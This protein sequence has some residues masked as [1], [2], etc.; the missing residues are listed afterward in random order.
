MRYDL[1]ITPW[2]HL[3]S[4]PLSGRNTLMYCSTRVP[5]RPESMIYGSQVAPTIR[6]EV[7]IRINRLLADPKIIRTCTAGSKGRW[8]EAFTAGRTR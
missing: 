8:P 7:L 4:N 1:D 2:D 5:T 3:Y 6:E